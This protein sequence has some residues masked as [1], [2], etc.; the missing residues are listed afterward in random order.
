MWTWLTWPRWER[1][2][3]TECWSSTGMFTMATASSTCSTKATKFS[4][5]LFT[6][7]ICDPVFLLLLVDQGIRC[8]F[9]VWWCDV[10]PLKWRRKLWH[11]RRRSW[12]RIQRE[13]S[14]QR[15]KDGRHRIP[16]G[17]PVRC[18]A[19][20]LWVRPPV[21]PGLRRVW[22][23]QRRSLGRVQALSWDVRPHDSGEFDDQPKLSLPF[24]GQGLL[25]L[26]GG[27][28]VVC[29]EGGYCLPA[30]SECM[31]QCARAILGDPLPQLRW[32]VCSLEDFHIHN[33]KQ[34]QTFSSLEA[35]VKLSAVDTVKDV[36]A[37][38]MPFW[39]CLAAYKKKLP[40][41]INAFFA[42]ADVEEVRIDE[43]PEEV[44]LGRSFRKMELV[45]EMDKNDF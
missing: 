39:D 40:H 26:A 41:D 35:E 22:R 3:W 17:L 10:L 34:C 4:T 2:A 36:I 5:F 12:P 45:S 16:D 37:A 8:I 24:A 32:L 33:V 29:L 14:F 25:G 11:G 20:R 38:Q 28:V 44:V 27:R 43:D 31:L 13:H 7:K 30:I 6:G 23:R 42:L 15:K 1:R 21:G 19:H 9:Q 18:Y